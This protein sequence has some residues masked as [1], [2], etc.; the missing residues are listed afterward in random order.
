MAA[1][2]AVLGAAF[3]VLLVF[4]DLPWNYPM[5]AAVVLLIYLG[6]FAKS[7]CLAAIR[8]GGTCRNNAR[9]LLRACHIQQH[10]RQ[11]SLRLWAQGRDASDL[12]KSG[13]NSVEAISGLASGIAAV[14]AAIGALLA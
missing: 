7:D 11:K 4:L 14:V 9:G 3:V 5:V 13:R 1:V 2:Q 10:K 8:G 6:L 12:L